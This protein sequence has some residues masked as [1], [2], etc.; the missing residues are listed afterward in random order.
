[1]NRRY[2][3]GEEERATRFARLFDYVRTQ[4]GELCLLLGNGASIGSGGKQW[5]EIADEIALKWKLDFPT[6]YSINEKFNLIFRNCGDYQ[7]QAILKRYLSDL[8]L[9]NGYRWLANLIKEG[10][11]DVIFTTNF[12]YLIN[13]SLHEVDLV[14]DIDFTMLLLNKRSFEDDIEKIEWSIKGVLSKLNDKGI[15]VKVVKLHGDLTY[16]DTLIITDDDIKAHTLT[17]KKVLGE[18]LNQNPQ[19]GILLVGYSGR[20]TDVAVALN[21]ATGNESVWWLNPNK[22][23]IEDPIASFVSTRG[24]F[25]H[26]A[27]LGDDGKFDTVFNELHNKLIKSKRTTSSELDT[28]LKKMQNVGE[29]KG[30]ENDIDAIITFLESHTIV[31]PSTIKLMKNL[32]GDEQLQLLDIVSRCRYICNTSYRLAIRSYCIGIFLYL[33]LDNDI[34]NNKEKLRR[35]IE[36]GGALFSE[37]SIEQDAKKMIQEVFEAGC[38]GYDLQAFELSVQDQLSSLESEKIQNNSYNLS[39]EKLDRIISC[40]DRLIEFQRFANKTRHTLDLRNFEKTFL[41]MANNLTEIV[42]PVSKISYYPPHMAEFIEK[43]NELERKLRVLPYIITDDQI[44]QYNWL[45]KLNLNYDVD[46]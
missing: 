14:Q 12:D 23:L 41:E 38:T 30:Q 21:E 1:M 26:N 9:S 19:K 42:H 45:A 33:L 6:E 43:C 22:P 15:N 3:C 32:S 25:P 29:G 44:S 34:I 35:L 20:D 17:V 24:V 27:I 8:P 36:R 13:K 16:P 39:L 28:I 18:Y 46:S 5:D 2:V 31:I 11:F 37:C 7:R 4:K 10:Y 40:F